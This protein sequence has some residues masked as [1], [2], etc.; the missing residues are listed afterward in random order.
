MGQELNATE[1]KSVRDAR[2]D[3]NRVRR[4][5]HHAVRTDDMEATRRFYEDILGLPM[6]IAMKESF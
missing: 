5:H 3:R 4:L 1:L 6:V 2:W